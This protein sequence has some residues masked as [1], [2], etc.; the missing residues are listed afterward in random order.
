[1]ANSTA[2]KDAANAMLLATRQFIEAIEAEEA[3]SGGTSAVPA[4]MVNMPPETRAARPDV[5][6]LTT[7][8]ATDADANAKAADDHASRTAAS[9]AIKA[10][11]DASK[12]PK[13]TARQ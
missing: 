8:Q 1:M 11:S 13:P 2:V 10:E 6:A 4:H 3:A 5:A 12:A 9:D 7:E